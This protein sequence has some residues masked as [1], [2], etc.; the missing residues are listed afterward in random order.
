MFYDK[1]C[2]L[3]I[4]FTEPYINISNLQKKTDTRIQYFVKRNSYQNNV[5]N[6]F[7]NPGTQNN[8]RVFISRNVNI[9][10]RE[11]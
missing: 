2:M 10:V 1:D 11:T 9:F 3:I 4:Y 8:L 6:M 5:S 7:L